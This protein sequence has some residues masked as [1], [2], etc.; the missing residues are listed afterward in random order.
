MDNDSEFTIHVSIDHEHLFAVFW[1][2]TC[3]DNTPLLP[4]MKSD[5]NA[6]AKDRD[7]NEVVDDYSVH[8]EIMPAKMQR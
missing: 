3:G 1:L 5:Y 7:M 6:A 8:S 4:H 2:Y